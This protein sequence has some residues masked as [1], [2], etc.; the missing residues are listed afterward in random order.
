MK[1]R[2]EEMERMREHVFKESDQNKDRL[3]SFP[4]F[5]AETKRDEF[6]KDPGWDTIDKEGEEF[7]EEEYK[8][9]ELQRQQ[10]IQDMLNRGIVPP[11]YPYYGDLPPGADPYQV[12]PQGTADKLGQQPASQP[13]LNQQQNPGQAQIHEDLQPPQ[14]H[15]VKQAG[16]P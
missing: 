5:L 15:E 1:E 2:E 11:G 14:P 10:E 3:I 4:E 12:P 16:Q 6:D 8:A 9:Y 13:N 7:T